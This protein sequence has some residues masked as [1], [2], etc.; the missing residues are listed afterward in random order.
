MP[1]VNGSAPGNLAASDWQ[2]AARD[3]VV[4]AVSLGLAALVE[5]GADLLD[6]AAG[7]LDQTDFGQGVVYAVC[8]LIVNQARRFVSDTRT[9]PVPGKILGLALAAI[10]FLA[11]PAQAQS[12]KIVLPTKAARAGTLVEIE[13]RT[14]AAEGQTIDVVEWTFPEVALADGTTFGEMVRLA[15]DGKSFLVAWPMGGDFPLTVEAF[16]PV[17][18]DRGKLK[19]IRR[20]RDRRVLKLSGGLIGPEP[21]EPAPPPPAPDLMPLVAGVTTAL[22]DHQTE[23]FDLSKA[24]LALADVFER[25]AAQTTDQARAIHVN[26]AKY[27]FYGQLAGKVPG[28]GTAVDQVLQTALGLESA[29]LDPAKRARLVATFRALAWAARQTQG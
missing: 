24:W 11:G 28:L 18:D 22:K 4:L 21:D 29:A 5:K 8:F 27:T 26:A 16:L 3:A 7:K 12:L 1:A 23:A 14:E 17:L 9:G 19:A 10:L 13:C 2:K 25:G 20:I 6:L 15:P